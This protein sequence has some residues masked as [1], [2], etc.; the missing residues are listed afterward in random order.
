MTVRKIV[1]NTPEIFVF[2][3][4]NVNYFVF[5]VLYKSELHVRDS[6]TEEI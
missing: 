3:H 6:K 5:W 1:E 4:S 2:Q